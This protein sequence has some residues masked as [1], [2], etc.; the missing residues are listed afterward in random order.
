MK[1]FDE[2]LILSLA[3]SITPICICTVVDGSTYSD[4][5]YFCNYMGKM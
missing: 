4:Y 2:R 5:I 3:E 1:L